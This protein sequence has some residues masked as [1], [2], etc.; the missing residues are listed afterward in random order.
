MVLRVTKVVSYPV[1]DL[2]ADAP[3]FRQTNVAL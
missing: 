2:V 3:E 1:D